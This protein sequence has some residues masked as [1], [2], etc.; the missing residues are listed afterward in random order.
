MLRV[1]EE[2]DYKTDAERNLQCDLCCLWSPHSTPE[3]KIILWWEIK[4]CQ[5]SWLSSCH[6]TTNSRML[7]LN[8][9]AGFVNCK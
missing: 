7:S 8:Y 2:Y 9:F 1:L 3:T 5:S 6:S 4:Y